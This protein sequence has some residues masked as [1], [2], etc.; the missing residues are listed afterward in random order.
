MNSGGGAYPDPLPPFEGCTGGGAQPLRRA[1]TKAPALPACCRPAPPQR[2]LPSTLA[3][4][5]PRGLA[6]VRRGRRL[7][8]VRVAGRS[9]GGPATFPIRSGVRAPVS[10]TDAHVAEPATHRQLGAAH[11]CGWPAHAA[12][13]NGSGE[14]GDVPKWVAGGIA[15]G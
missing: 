13:S 1:T 3:P 2:G 5:P 8:T 14:L 6:H 11:A 7:R 12:A 10:L 9:P 15:S 4:L